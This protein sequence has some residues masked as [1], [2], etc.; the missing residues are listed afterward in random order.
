MTTGEV[1]A[2]I[3][4]GIFGEKGQVALA[5]AAGGLVRWLTLRTR[6]RDGLVAIIVGCISAVYLHPLAE[7]VVNGILGSV[8][9]EDSSRSAF[10]GFIIGLGGV[11][12]AGWVMDAIAARLRHKREKEEDDDDEQDPKDG[13]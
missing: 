2:A 3:L 13:R 9:V 5:G 1:V 8:V 12:V 4:S 6:L 10:S 7:P 11:G